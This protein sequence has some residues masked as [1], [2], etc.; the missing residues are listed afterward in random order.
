MLQIDTNQMLQLPL[1]IVDIEGEYHTLREQHSLLIAGR[2]EAA[3]IP[4]LVENAAGIAEL[5]LQRR[6]SV[7][8]DLSD[9]DQEE[10]QIILLAYFSH[11]WKLATMLKTPYA[12]VIEE[13]HEFLP[14]GQRTP[15]KS[16]LTRFALR[17]RKRGLGIIIASQRSA[18]VEKDLLTQAGLLFLHY[19]AHPTDL[20][21][22][23]DLVPLAAKEVEQQVRA[24]SPGGALFVHGAQ[25]EQIQV[26]LRS[27]S[28]AG[29]TPTLDGDQPRFKTI[30][31]ALLEELR[32][33]TARAV[34]EGVGDE[35]TQLRK[36]LKDAEAIIS[37]QQT[38]IQRQAEQIE[39][40]SKLSVQVKPSEVSALEIR[41]AVVQN[42]LVPALSVQ[43][44]PAHH[45]VDSTVTCNVIEQPLPLN[46]VKFR[47]LQMRLRQVPALERETL[48]VL[49]E[50]GRTL[51]MQ[52]IAAWLSKS[53]SHMQH[54]P[55][56]TLIKLGLVTRSKRGKTY[57][58]RASL[59]EYLRREFP[60]GDVQQLQAQLL[61]L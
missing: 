26:R 61:H 55:P 35:T 23:K 40:L 17:G 20:T 2:S 34:K 27:T 14:Q 24:L 44:P 1:T 8:L 6:I 30:D 45:V 11:L 3:D 36:Q 5:S 54:H 28:H 10:M 18:K 12:V 39:L 4:L 9:Y 33:L 16:L 19:V 48:R 41:Q 57:L 21:V 53:E 42:M 13:A 58:Y 37:R 60:G 15:L 31:A 59:I 22:Y 46:E 38:L 49:I 52:D 29:V 43:A 51:T 25:V 32:E 7:V 56:H 50:Q 47:S